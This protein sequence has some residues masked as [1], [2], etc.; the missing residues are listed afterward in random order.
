PAC[1]ARE[2]G[3]PVHTKSAVT[4]VPYR[5]FR[6]YW[7]PALA[8][9]ARSAGMTAAT[10]GLSLAR[11]VEM[12][13]IRR[14]LVLAQRHQQAVAVDKIVLADEHVLIA[15]DADVL[16]PDRVARAAIAPCDSPRTRQGVIDGGDLVEQQI[17]IGLV[18]GDTL[19]HHGL[20][21]FMQRNSARVEDARTLQ[22]ARL[23]HERVVTAA[24]P[25]VDPLADRV[26][27][28]R[29]LDAFRPVASI[30][31]DAAEFVVE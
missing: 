4:R 22:L 10:A 12:P 16:H 18:Q 5:S 28:K 6:G 24:A 23:D 31:V 2:S 9:C 15:L 3:H 1:H 17:G 26:A 30:G 7:I 29:W 21:V 19:L 20:V 11:L 27:G 14:R 25:R 8:R 13:Q